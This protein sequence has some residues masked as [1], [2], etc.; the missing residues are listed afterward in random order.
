MRKEPRS[1]LEWIECLCGVLQPWCHCG[2][3]GNTELKTTRASEALQL[4]IR[5]LDFSFAQQGAIKHVEIHS[6][7]KI[8]SPKSV[9]T[10]SISLDASIVF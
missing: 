1:T 7:S 10:V 8:S 4:M 6:K 9:S 5:T 2:V 3:G